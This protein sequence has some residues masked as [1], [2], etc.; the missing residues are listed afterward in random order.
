MYGLPQWLSGK[1]STC[2]DFPAGPVVKTLSSQCRGPKVRFL[3]REIDPTCCQINEL[4]KKESNYV[5]H[6]L[7]KKKK[8]STCNE[9]DTGDVNLLTGSGRSP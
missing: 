1:E 5:C 4:K 2:R 7:K 8:E 6:I 9:G 3:V